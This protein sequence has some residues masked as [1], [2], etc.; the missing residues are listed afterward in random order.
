MAE[1][2]HLKNAPIRAA[3][4]EVSLPIDE[5]STPAKLERLAKTFTGYGRLERIRYPWADDDDVSVRATSKQDDKHVVEVA[6]DGFSFTRFKPYTEWAAVKKEALRLWR[7]YLKNR[8]PS[9][10]SRI[11]VR[12][13]NHLKL[14]F[15]LPLHPEQYIL[16]LPLPPEGWPRALSNLLSRVTLFDSDR[17]LQVNVFHTL[18]DDP[19]ENKMGFGFDIEA[20]KEGS[21]LPV[22]AVAVGTVLDSLR[23]LKNEVFFKGLTERAVRMY[24]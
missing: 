7:I 22:S 19:E 12:Y 6:R 18:L 14:P 8:A 1:R 5:G 17:D 10:A 9:H 16:G 24:E 15:D 3:V 13:I 4:I 20:F 23:D 21:A 2:R 11:A